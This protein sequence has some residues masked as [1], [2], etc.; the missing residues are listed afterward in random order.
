[1][2][3]CPPVRHSVPNAGKKL[4]PFKSDNTTIKEEI[5]YEKD[6]CFDFG[7]C[8]DPLPLCLRQQGPSISDKLNQNATTASTEPAAPDVTEAP[9]TE[10]TEPKPRELAIVEWSDKNGDYSVILQS[11]EKFTDSQ[12]NPAIRLYYD[13]TNNSSYTCTSA[14]AMEWH[15]YQNEEK[16][17]NVYPPNG[18]KVSEDSHA[19]LNVRPGY[20]VRCIRQ[21]AF[22]DETAPIRVTLEDSKNNPL[23]DMEVT[24]DQIT[25]A[26]EVPFEP[27]LVADPQWLKDWP[28]EAVYHTDYVVA[29][30]STEVVEGYEGERML[31]VY[32]DFTNNSEEANSYFFAIY[33]TCVYQD[34]VEL[35]N[36]FAAEM[37]ESDNVYA[38]KIDPGQ[39]ITLSY[40]YVLRTDSPVEIEVLDPWTD[41]NGE[42]G[43]VGL[44]VPVA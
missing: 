41:I 34:G 4:Q 19:L 20:S 24:V 17:S 2:W 33:S 14:D 39:S 10:A 28:S 16:L 22:P 40:C 35:D 30:Q 44:V 37:V 18:E 5:H 7:A 15:I 23:M 27:A 12:G 32:F 1:M 38:D 9:T 25:G 42:D 3:C 43:G 13:F 26:P 6:L 11:I 36:G 8:F 29:I 31:R 21:V